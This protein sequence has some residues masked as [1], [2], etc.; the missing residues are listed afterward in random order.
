MND[1]NARLIVKFNADDGYVN[2][3]ADRIEKD[4][5]MFYAF[6]GKELVGAFDISAVLA[7]YIS[8]KEVA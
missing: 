2:I 3:A 8:A 6:L 4:D 1:K 7:V 5:C